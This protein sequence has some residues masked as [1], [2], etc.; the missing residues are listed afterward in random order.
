MPGFL[1][2]KI[3]GKPES[4]DL[5]ACQTQLK[6]GLHEGASM[7]HPSSFVVGEQKN[8]GLRTP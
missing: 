8:R 7:K 5:V 1:Y 2:L 6:I 4:F 3:R